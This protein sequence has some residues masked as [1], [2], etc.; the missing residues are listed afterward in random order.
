MGSIASAPVVT[1]VSFRRHNFQD[2]GGSRVSYE[3]PELILVLTD[4]NERRS[5]SRPVPLLVP[6]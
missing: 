5:V 2:A 4:I 3:L 1:H 6:R